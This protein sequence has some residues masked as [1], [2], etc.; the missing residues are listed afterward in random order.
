MIEPGK[1]RINSGRGIACMVGGM[2]VLTASD[3]VVKWLTAGYPTGEIIFVRGLFVLIPILLICLRSGGGLAGL[4]VVNVRGQ[5]L[6]AVMFIVSVFCFLTGL[7]Y[8]P[9]ALNVAIAFANPLFITALAP[10]MLGEHVGWRRWCAVLAGFAGVLIIVQPY[11]DV[12]NIYALLPLGAAAAGAFRDIVTRQISPTDSS[13]SML[14][15]STAAVSL[16]GLLTIAGGNWQ[17]PPLSDFGWMVLTGVM[18]GIAHY[19]LIE[20]FVVAEAAL[21]APFRYS[22]LL[23]GVAL[24]YILWDELPAVHDWI[25]I[26]LLVGSGLYIIHRQ[27]T[28][29]KAAPSKG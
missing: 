29:R 14:F 5:V 20:A 23:W 2:G 24:G 17:A 25:G 18:S 3:A 9:L 22:A 21:V 1:Y 12:L 10:A 19:L 26:T 27:A 6:R 15:W 13:A 7:R 11:G 4:R 28:L 8:N 16:A